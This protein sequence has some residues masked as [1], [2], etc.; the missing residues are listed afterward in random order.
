ML[1]L[2]KGEP[3]HR[4]AVQK[5]AT[6]LNW[7]ALQQALVALKGEPW[8]LFAERRAFIRSLSAARLR[9]TI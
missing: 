8:E 4:Q 2:A 6:R 7:A 3:A 9:G 1:Q 5:R